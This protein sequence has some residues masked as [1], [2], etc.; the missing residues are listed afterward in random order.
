MGDKFQDKYSI[1]SARLQNWDYGWNAPY[2]VTI[3]IKN[4]EHYFG[5][6]L[7]KKMQLSEIGKI[8]ESEWVKSINIRPDMNLELGEFVIMPNHFHGIV[9]IGKNRYN[10]DD[11][12]NIGGNVRGDV[13]D[14]NDDGV[15]RGRDAMHCV[16]MVAVPIT[17]YRFRYGCIQDTLSSA[18]S[19]AILKVFLIIGLVFIIEK[20]SFLVTL[21]DWRQTLMKPEA[22]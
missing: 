11:G 20:L 14:N 22:M 12:D 5:E 17:D 9:I 8:V 3:C 6:I 7:D 19:P 16:S 4:R 2:F 13:G 10:R 18:S 1:S 21:T 15:G